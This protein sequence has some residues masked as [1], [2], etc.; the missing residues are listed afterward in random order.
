VQTPRH[1]GLTAWPCSTAARRSGRV[2]GLRRPGEPARC[3]RS[4]CRWARRSR[5][6]SKRIASP[7]P[8]ISTL[9]HHLNGRTAYPVRREYTG[10]CVRAHMCGHL[11]SPSHFTVSCRNTAT[12]IRRTTGR[13]Q[14]TFSPVQ[15]L[16]MQELVGV[17]IP[18][19]PPHFSWSAA[20]K[21]TAGPVESSPFGS[22]ATGGRRVPFMDN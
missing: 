3:W 8:A 16:F 22:T 4:I 6:V 18:L 13:R 9:A 14:R 19:A 11:R 10:R 17:R 12:H 2:C 1:A 15:S 20:R 5:A 21:L 7:T